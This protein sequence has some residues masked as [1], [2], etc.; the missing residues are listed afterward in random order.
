M[1]SRIG[2]LI[3]ATALAVA[4]A[5]AEDMHT[6]ARESLLQSLQLPRVTQEARLL[7]VGDRDIRDMFVMARDNRLTTGD[8]T[9]LFEVE[10][11]A[12]REHGPVDNFGAFVQARLNQGLRGKELAAAIHAEHAA[13]GMGKGNMPGQYGHPGGKGDSPMN[14]VEGRKP[15]SPDRP[16]APGGKPD[17]SKKGGPAK[18]RKGGTR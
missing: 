8:L 18:E 11:E 14:R 16:G 17:P 10:N 13:R 12:I 2:I 3:L 1:Q 6:M 9:R 4:P 7:G 5:A 15:G